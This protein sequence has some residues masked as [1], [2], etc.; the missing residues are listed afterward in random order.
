M[1]EQTKLAFEFAGTWARELITLSTG[2]LAVS[3]TFTKDV[4][5]PKTGG[6]G[7]LGTAW[8][9]YLLTILL[10]MG[11]LGG[12]TGL[13]M[14]A[15]PPP[16]GTP[17]RFHS[18]IRLFASAQ[19]ISFVTGTVLIIVYGVRGLRVQRATDPIRKDDPPA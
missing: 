18:T 2:I 8:V 15:T 4:L 5:Q 10:G 12:L 13:L 16:A 19:L 17:L 6:V 9:F 1:E 14:P 11:V 7:W 3:I